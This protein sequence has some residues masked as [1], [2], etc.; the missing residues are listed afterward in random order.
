MSEFPKATVIG[1]IEAWPR[2]FIG[3]DELNFPVEE[4][5]VGS[6]LGE[7][8]IEVRIPVDGVQ[9]RKND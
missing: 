3:E 8:Y 6:Y 1:N 4:V 5:S 9:I 7:T 2:V